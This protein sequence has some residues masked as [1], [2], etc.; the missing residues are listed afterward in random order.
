MLTIV[1]AY[2]GWAIN[3]NSDE[4]HGLLGRYW[5]FEGTPPIIP[6]HLHGHEIAVFKTRREARE[7]LPRVRRAFK[8]ARVERVH[9]DIS[10]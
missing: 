10:I 6:D 9:I 1:K 4:G 5:W 2:K 7:A 3:T 8:K